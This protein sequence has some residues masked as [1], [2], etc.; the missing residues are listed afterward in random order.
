MR[1]VTYSSL[2]ANGLLLTMKFM[3]TV[4]SS[5]ST[6]GS[7][8]IC[9]ASHTVSPILTSG[10]PAMATISPQCVCC[11]SL[12]LSPANSE[13]RDLHWLRRTVVAAKRRSH[14]FF[15][16]TARNTPNAI[17]PQIIIV[18]DAR[19]KICKGPSGSPSG[20][21]TCAMMASKESHD[22]A[23][24]IVRFIRCSAV[25]RG[26]IH[27]GEV[28]LIFRCAKFDKKIDDAVKHRLSVRPACPPY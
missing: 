4:G 14:I 8:S 15:R 20:A 24:H 19:H 12:R 10:S 1:D 6:N 16:R 2:P 25:L 21:G 9:S 26:S 5:I 7:C 11:V 3:E 13:P 18:I 17:A 27:H 23:A 22:I 28:E